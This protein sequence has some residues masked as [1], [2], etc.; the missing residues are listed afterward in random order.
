MRAARSI[1][2]LTLG[3]GWENRQVAGD[4]PLLTLP[5]PS[6]SQAPPHERRPG[7]ELSRELELS[8]FQTHPNPRHLYLL[9]LVCVSRRK[10]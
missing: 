7:E 9:P 6:P 5:C 1:P 4:R 8:S 3:K 10:L 2:P